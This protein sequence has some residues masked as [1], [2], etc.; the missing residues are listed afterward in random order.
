[1]AATCVAQLAT[2]ARESVYCRQRILKS[3]TGW[4]ERV[5]FQPL[6]EA[7]LTG[8]YSHVGG[9]R[10]AVHTA[11]SFP[12]TKSTPTSRVCITLILLARSWL[13]P[14]LPPCISSNSSPGR[15]SSLLC[16]TAHLN[17]NYLLTSFPSEHKHQPQHTPRSIR[18]GR[19]T[20]A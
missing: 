20:F 11:N 1:M 9:R 18:A 6:S 17:H 15:C 2:D 13:A 4:A 5:Q 8:T 7:R 10:D 12:P 19:G 16:A 3:T 14:L